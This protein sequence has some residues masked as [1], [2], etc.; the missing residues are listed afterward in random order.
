M[1]SSF[2]NIEIVTIAVYLLGG[3][4]NY[5]DTEDIAMKVNELAPGRFTWRKYP[6]QINIS[7]VGKRLAD[8]KNEKK[9]GLLIG[10]YKKGWML[11]NNGLKFCK[12]RIKDLEINNLSRKPISKKELNWKKHEKNRML[13]CVA[14]VKVVENRLDEITKPEI[15]EFFRIDDY[16]VGEARERK[17]TLIVNTFGEDSDL[18]SMIKVLYERIKKNDRAR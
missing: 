6:D 18:G 7:N 9:G 8:G 1:K 14:Y 17:L 12:T 15:E 11:S 2:S 4:S 5:I 16:I 10:S 3:A 13:S